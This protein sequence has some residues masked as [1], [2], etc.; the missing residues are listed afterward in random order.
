MKKYHIFLLLLLFGM[1]GCAPKLPELEKIDR[2][3]WLQENWGTEDD[4]QWY[5]HASQGT[6]TF[7][8]PYEWFMALEVPE[9][10]FFGTPGLLSDNAYLLRFGFLPGE[11]SQ[12][13]NAGL[14]VGFAVDFDFQ[15]MNTGEK[16]HAIGLTCAACHTGR[17]IYKGT[18]LRIDGGSAN[19][20][21]DKLTQALG[22]SLVYTNYVPGR[23]DRFAQ[24]VLD[25]EDTPENR[26]ALRKKFDQ[27]LA[28]LNK[29]N[30][31][32]KDV[33]GKS[34]SEGVGRIDALNR[35]GNQVFA[36][37]PDRKDNYYP[38]TAPVNY[39][40]IW[41]A[42]WYAWVQYDG[43]IMQPMV[44]NAGESLGVSSSLNLVG[45]KTDQYS[46]SVRV[47]NL[48]RMENMLAGT[49]PPRTVKKFT[50]LNSPEWPEDVLGQIDMEKAKKGEE[51]Y[52]Q[53]CS[54]CH[55]QATT[56]D[57]GFWTDNANWVDSEKKDYQ[58]IDVKDIPIE[59]VG[60]D[61]EQANV[62]LNRTIDAKGFFTPTDITAVAGEGCKD[63]TSTTVK[64]D[65]EKDPLFA[66][67]LGI[68]VE[69]AIDYFYDQNHFPEAKRKEYNRYRPNDL[70]ACSE[71]S[72]LP[73]NG[74]WAT[75]PFL[76][77]GSVPSLYDL[78]SPVSER[79]KTFH[80]GS[81][82]FD[83]VHVGYST[84]NIEGSFKMDTSISGNHNTGH[85]FNDGSGKGIIGPKLQEIDRMALIEYLKTL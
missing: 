67:S 29:F 55:M 8:V 26:K 40:F 6:A 46:S 5:R 74:V 4:R 45:N 16:Y 2:V 33:S 18:D 80:M 42:P 39:P 66:L 48:H 38:T 7:P 24:R 27:I 62:V 84:T 21:L 37:D 65:P 30:D 28:D 85:E 72:A 77:N 76:H 64:V 83:P 1:T 50:G 23:F 56:P 70:R 17:L 15:D 35:I 53:Y 51:L 78:L 63:N 47:D 10:S 3:I 14:P 49:T 71:Y 31:W 32:D 36:V 58:Y 41:N 44:R 52:K 60:T 68:V 20:N 61:P 79:P 9:I 81:N 34:V 57:S 22:V 12:Y 11:R 69:K 73:L 25:E 54:K 19:I 13:N 59:V 43:S 75:P 82:Q